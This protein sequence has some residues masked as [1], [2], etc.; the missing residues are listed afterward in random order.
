MKNGKPGR[1]GLRTTKVS[2]VGHADRKSFA[3]LAG[4]TT[5]RA[6]LNSAHVAPA[7]RTIA[8]PVWDSALC[9]RRATCPKTDHGF[10]SRLRT[11]P[12]T[13]RCDRGAHGHRGEDRGAL[14][15]R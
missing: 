2:V 6:C 12:F 8:I 5:F 11:H 1:L 4:T 3:G 7:N 14:S 15:D 9:S 10:R 13:A